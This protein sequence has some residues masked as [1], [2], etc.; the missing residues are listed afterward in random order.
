M[1]LSLHQ[2]LV[3]FTWFPLAVLLTFLILI[4]RFF[5]KFSDERTFFRWFL[6]PLV[7]FGAAAVRDAST[8]RI[9]DDPIVDVLSGISGLM[10]GWLSLRLYWLMALKR[11]E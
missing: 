7:L 5:E 6:V 3:L 2:F 8:P 1:S 4:A 9:G 10:L 11:R